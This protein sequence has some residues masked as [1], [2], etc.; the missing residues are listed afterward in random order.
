MEVRLPPASWHKQIDRV[1]PGSCSGWDWFGPASNPNGFLQRQTDLPP[2]TVVVSYDMTGKAYKGQASAFVL[3][4]GPMLYRLATVTANEFWST[5]LA[6][7]VRPMLAM[8]VESRLLWVVGQFLSRFDS[9]DFHD[10]LLTTPELMLTRS[11]K[12]AE[13][14][15]LRML[16]AGRLSQNPD[17]ENEYLA[18]SFQLWLAQQSIVTGQTAREVR[19]TLQQRLGLSTAAASVSSRD[20]MSLRVSLD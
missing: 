19:A 7:Y 1:S 8:A 10:R 14:K 20:S 17:I 15:A 4:D 3:L 13:I 18:A 16:Y 12:S 2:G 11:Q 6:P 5:T 9:P